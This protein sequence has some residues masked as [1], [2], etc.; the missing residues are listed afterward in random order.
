MKQ[1]MKIYNLSLL[2]LAQDAVVMSL[3]SCI[4]TPYSLKENH[5]Y[6]YRTPKDD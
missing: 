3:F 4:S 5:W 6:I 2:P 1:Y